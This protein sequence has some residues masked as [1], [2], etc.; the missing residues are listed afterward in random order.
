MTTQSINGQYLVISADR[1]S[2]PN[3]LPAARYERLRDAIKHAESVTYKMAVIDSK[4][5]SRG[6]IYI[7]WEVAP[8]SSPWGAV[9][10][11]NKL[12]TGIWAVSTCSHGGIHLSDARLAELTEMIGYEFPTFCGDPNWFE[13]DCDWCVVPVA[14]QTPGHYEAACQCLRGLARSSFNMRYQHVHDK[15]IEAGKIE[16]IPYVSTPG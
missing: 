15:L 8:A 12:A 7:N 11:Y 1:A 10:S 6:Y 14:F 16:P 3:K 5:E 9:E 4:A 13:E 2:N